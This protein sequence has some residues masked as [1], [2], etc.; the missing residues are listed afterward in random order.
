MPFFRN[1]NA[2]K[3]SMGDM[4]AEITSNTTNAHNIPLEN[5]EYG[6]WMFSSTIMLRKV[7]TK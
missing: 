5:I 2:I 6:I 1:F 7:E 4:I 3:Y